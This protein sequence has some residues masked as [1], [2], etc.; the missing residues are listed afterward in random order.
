M[1]NIEWNKS[2]WS[3]DIQIFNE[4]LS[5]KHYPNEKYYGDR[6]GEVEKDPVLKSIK[7]RDPAAKSQLTILLT[8]PGVKATIIH[9]FTHR[10]WDF[11]MY[12][13]AR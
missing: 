5:R 11:K 13:F 1:P 8:Y 7:E 3:K 6:W 12:L 9:W 4:G 2:Y 10:L